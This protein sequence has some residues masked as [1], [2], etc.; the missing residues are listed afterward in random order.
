MIFH[1]QPLVS[2]PFFFGI[3]C[4][5][6]MIGFVSFIFQWKKGTAPYRIGIRIVLFLGFIVCLSLAILRPQRE[7]DSKKAAV[8]VYQDGLS[9]GE[10]DR[11]KDSLAINNAVPLAK[12]KGNAK[13]VFLL[14][15]HFGRQQLF[16]FRNLDFQWIQ[17]EKR[18]TLKDLSWKGYL[19]KGEIQRVGYEI[20]IDTDSA[21]LEV[22]GSGLE[23]KS[24]SKGWNS[25]ILQFYPSGLG[26]A[27]FPLILDNDSIASIRFFIG[28]SLPKKYHF[29]LGF[30]SAE[31]R[32]LSNWLREKGE[33]VSE[34]IK[35]SRETFLQSGRAS[36]S[37]QVYL[38]DP[39]QLDQKNLQ[40]AVK[41][42]NAALV[43][44][45]IGQ[46]VE[47]AQ[48]L[49]RLFE[50]DFQVERIGQSEERTLEN[51]VGAMPFA[52]V[53][54]THQKLLQEGSVAI[55]YAGSS[56][57]AMSL[58]SSSYPLLRQGKKDMY[59]S[60]WGELI[61]ILEPDEA[62][63]WRV[64]APLISEIEEEIKLFSKDGLPNEL[65]WNADTLA[66]R[67]NAVNPF[68]AS[69][70]IR[71]DT[72]GWV[73]LD[74][75]FSVYSYGKEELPSLQTSA[76][77]QE[78]RASVASGMKETNARKPVSPW[79]WLLG[80]TVSLGLLWLEPKSTI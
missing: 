29:Q 11:W 38:V 62:N 79:I 46:P 75:A 47:T 72:T 39:A 15:E 2:W 42:G 61:G 27:E 37:L 80:M 60:V 25:G 40:T 14:G 20:F 41:S 50:T 74:S 48:K 77:I 33:S 16:P 68:L 13:E 49:N 73:D 26:K 59:E 51:G 18:G 58:V 9:K 4:I 21:K 24:L 70:N 12:Y 55:Q 63:A 69:G 30:P 71:I 1:Y 66:L 23:G 31:S 45:N 8:L 44:L 36:D 64:D 10:I 3:L 76:F 34:D 53:D 5:L 19:R 22:A 52:F 78:I 54:K 7:I 65:I 43:V 35:V 56:P 67:Q 28:A 32:T 17:P 57:I 6:V